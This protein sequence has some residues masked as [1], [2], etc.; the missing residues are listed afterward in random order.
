MKRKLAVIG[1]S[2][3]LLSGCGGLRKKEPKPDQ[4]QTVMLEDLSKMIQDLGSFQT[5][6]DDI[7]DDALLDN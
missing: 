7:E 2:V 3:L 5:S 6:Q 1:L 4:A